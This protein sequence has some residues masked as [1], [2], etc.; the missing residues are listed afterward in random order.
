MN[1]REFLK[2]TG[3]AAISLPIANSVQAKISPEQSK[4]CEPGLAVE[5]DFVLLKGYIYRYK[6]YDIRRDQMMYLY[7]VY[8]KT[9]TYTV[10]TADLQDKI[11]INHLETQ[12]IKGKVRRKDII[13]PHKVKAKR[14]NAIK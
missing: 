8:T 6:Q 11:S 2:L 7:A 9:D 14:L 1:R 4:D 3:L 10:A 5:N 12:L 13:L